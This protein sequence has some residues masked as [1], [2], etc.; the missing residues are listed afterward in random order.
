M[1]ILFLLRVRGQTPLIDE[2][3]R[4]FL[5]GS[6]IVQWFLCVQKRTRP[7][8][9]G[10]MERVVKWT[11]MKV[12]LSSF[13]IFP[14]RVFGVILTTA[15]ATNFLALFILRKEM[16]LLGIGFR[17]ILFLIGLASIR[18]TSSW[19]EVKEGSLFFRILEG[20]NKGRFPRKG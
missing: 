10:W 12:L 20:R 4:D 8:L 6:V 9:R 1:W 11:G 14:L 7:R 15:V 17:L 2:Q 3:T 5:K 19:N 18:N 13:T 16:G